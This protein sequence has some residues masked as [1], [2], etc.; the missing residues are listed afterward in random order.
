[1]R[2]STQTTYV[3]R[4]DCIEEMGEMLDSAMCWANV[5]RQREIGARVLDDS[6]NVPL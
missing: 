5:A 1:V 2:R 4:Q 3:K 6:K